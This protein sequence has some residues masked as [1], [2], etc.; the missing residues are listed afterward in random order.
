MVG[1]L[2][3]QK[4]HA[5]R[6]SIRC[7][8]ELAT[9][10]AEHSRDFFI[11][12]GY[13][14]EMERM[15]EMMELESE[16]CQPSNEEKAIAR[17]AIRQ[18]WRDWS[19]EATAERNACFSPIIDDIVQRFYRQDRSQ[20][21]ILIPGSG[22]NR[23]GFNLS[24]AGYDVE[25]NEVSYIHL[26]ATNFILSRTNNDHG[27]VQRP[28]FPGTQSTFDICPWNLSFSNNLKTAHQFTKYTVPEIMPASSRYLGQPPTLDTTAPTLA[29]KAPNFSLNGNNFM[30]DYTDALSAGQY[31]IVVTCF[32]IDT[33]PNFLSYIR[34]IKHLLKPSG[35]WINVGPL[36]WNCFENGPGG[37]REGDI[38][39]DE[40]TQARQQPPVPQHPPSQPQQSQNPMQ[41]DPSSQWDRKLEFSH[42][43]VIVL[44]KAMGF[45]VRQDRDVGTAG[46]CFDDRGLMN[47]EY[48]LRFWVAVKEEEESAVAVPVVPRR[49]PVDVGIFDDRIG[50]MNAW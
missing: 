2:W 14:A 41:E 22:L 6:D 50:T 3:T 30:T 9:A 25:A 46:Y 47:T 11:I 33:A 4:E 21:K 1:D 13:A 48:K 20:I 43:E 12:Q 27:T 19:F 40:D 18:I 17:S 44:L 39:I 32:F 24:R 10:I 42:E 34:T 5:L 26:L 31:D 36:L 16:N 49:G 45:T 29:F 23:L 28:D 15:D 38:T 35:V 7:N 37:R 8:A